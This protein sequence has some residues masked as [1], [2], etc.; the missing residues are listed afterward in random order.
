MHG[1]PAMLAIM[2]ASS[3]NPD[4]HALTILARVYEQYGLQASAWIEDFTRHGGTVFCKSGC[5]HCCNL[6]I[7]VS[8]LEALLTAS[9]LSDLQLESMKTRAREILENARVASSWDDYFLSHRSKVG[10]CPLLDQTTGACT[11]YE[12]R[13]GRC[14]DTYSAMNAHFCTVGTLET[15]NR[16]ERSE[17]NREVEANPVTDGVT[18]Y[19]APLEDLGTNIWEVASRSMRSGWGFEIWGDFWVL[20]ALTQDEAFMTAVRAGQV[21]QARKRAKTIGLWNIEILEIG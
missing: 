11:A 10:Y 21:K 2:S 14:R 20:T 19:I 16:R 15:M 17:Y 6:P 5:L 18:H 1:L 7:R 9:Q 8:L 12:V 3:S 4:Q 13:P